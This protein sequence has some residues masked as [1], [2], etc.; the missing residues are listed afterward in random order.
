MNGIIKLKACLKSQMHASVNNGVLVT[1]HLN[2]LTFIILPDEPILGNDMPLL[3]LSGIFNVSLTIIQ[4]AYI[5]YTVDYQ[6][7]KP[8]FFKHCYLQNDFIIGSRKL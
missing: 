1:E 3:Y 5:K 7:S 4:Q 6:L 8:L 2:Y